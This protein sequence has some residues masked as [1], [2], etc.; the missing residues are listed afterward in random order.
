MKSVTDETF[1]NDVVIRSETL[2]VIVDLWA[3]WCEPCKSLTPILETVVAK[4]NG[5]VELV[6]VN[7]DEKSTNTTDF[8]SAEYPRR[9]RI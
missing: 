1:N 6:A 4:T 3:P 7:I 5:D 2:P 8:P 9:V